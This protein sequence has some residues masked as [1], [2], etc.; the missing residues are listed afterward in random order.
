MGKIVKLSVI[1]IVILL[2]FVQLVFAAITVE[3]TDK[4][5]GEPLKLMTRSD[6]SLR[7]IKFVSSSTGATSG[8]RYRFT[9]TKLN[10]GG[11]EYVLSYENVVGGAKPPAGVTE[12][13]EIIITRD[14]ILEGVQ[15]QL[16][17]NLTDAEL[18]QFEEG[19][20]NPKKIDIGA[21]IEIYNANTGKVLDRITS[22]GDIKRI[23]G[24]HGFSQKHM[25]DMA[26]RFKKGDMD[27]PGDEDGNSGVSG[28]GSGRD[29]PSK[30]LR[31]SI[32]KP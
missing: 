18:K 22:V 24:K 21:T 15:Q 31:P 29:N 27:R 16:G 2:L 30:G 5:A 19:M 1:S 17:R 14:D 8:I 11:F 23:A 4:V 12:H 7:E 10:I 3:K 28:Y 20:K 13:Y 26:T 25:N 32:I 6:G 9:E